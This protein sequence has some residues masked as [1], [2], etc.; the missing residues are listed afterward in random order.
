MLAKYDAQ[1]PAALRRLIASGTNLRPFSR[2]IMDAAEKAS[3]EVYDELGKK[4]AHWKRIY[5]EWK[6]FRDEEFLWFRVAENTYDNYT[7]TSKAGAS[8]K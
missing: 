8:K 7:F 5:P 1:N 4:S 3:Y 6:K 2:A